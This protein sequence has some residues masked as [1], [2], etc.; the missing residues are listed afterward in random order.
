[1]FFGM[2]SASGRQLLKFLPA[3]VCTKIIA[4][5]R[6]FKQFAAIIVWML[7]VPGGDPTK[8]SRQRW[9]QHCCC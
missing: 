5:A 1:M 8:K 4:Q 7:Y 9:A 3:G 2:N 6:K